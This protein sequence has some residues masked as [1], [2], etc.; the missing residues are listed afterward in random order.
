MSAS[1]MKMPEPTIEPT[2]SAVEEKRP[3]LWTRWGAEVESPAGWAVFWPE[4]R[5]G[6]VTC[7][8]IYDGRGYLHS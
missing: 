4:V 5:F 6:F 3:R 7:K 8:R 2:T 1:T